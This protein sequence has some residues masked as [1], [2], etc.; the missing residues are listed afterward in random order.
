MNVTSSGSDFD[1][2]TAS[3]AR[4]TATRSRERSSVTASASLN[5]SPAR[6]CSRV[7]ATGRAGVGVSVAATAETLAHGRRVGEA[8]VGSVAQR[9]G[10]GGQRVEAAQPL[11]LALAE[12]VA[13]ALEVAGEV[14]GGER[15]APRGR[16]RHLG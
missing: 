4:P 14:P 15:M 13:Q 9:A 10:L 5:R 8:E 2:R 12:P 1:E 11:A 16:A 7:S 3:A 6:A